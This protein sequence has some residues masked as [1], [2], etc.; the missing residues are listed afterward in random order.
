MMKELGD[1]YVK[2]EFK[3]FK[4][5][6]EKAMLD[7]FYNEWDMYLASLVVRNDRYGK[8]MAKTEK[9]VLTDEQK[10]KLDDLVKI[11]RDKPQKG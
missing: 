9:L 5:V 1:S 2:N 6:K 4:D 8:D 3:L 11:V 10:A 7:K